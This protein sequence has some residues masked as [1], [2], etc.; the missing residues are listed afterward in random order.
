MGDIDYG[1]RVELDPNIELDNRPGMLARVADALAAAK[2]NIEY[3]YSA[4]REGTRPTAPRPRTRR[5]AC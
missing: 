1:E 3:C 2:I 5:R 4:P